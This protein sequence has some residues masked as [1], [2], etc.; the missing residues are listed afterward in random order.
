[1]LENTC[2]WVIDGAATG[3]MFVVLK[4]D[5]PRKQHFFPVC[6]FPFNIFIPLQPKIFE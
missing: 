2:K 1:L 6:R 5:E 3:E 4:M